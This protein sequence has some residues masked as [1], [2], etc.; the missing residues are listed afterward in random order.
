MIDDLAADLW[1]PRFWSAHAIPEFGLT[2]SSNVLE[3]FAT[4]VFLYNDNYHTIPEVI[5]QV[6]KA[7]GCSRDEG[8]AV[9]WEVH[10]RGQALVFE[11]EMLDCLNVSS[12]LE[13]IS[14]LTQVTT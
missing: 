8:A 4:R 5:A 13:E 14:L 3:G 12:V 2:E 6:R 11:G 9:A 1:P 7:V 10:T